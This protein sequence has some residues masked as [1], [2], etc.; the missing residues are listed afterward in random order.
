MEA[1]RLG[2]PNHTPISGLLHFLLSSFVVNGF[3]VYIYLYCNGSWNSNRS[4]MYK[5]S[6]LVLAEAADSDSRIRNSEGN[7]MNDCRGD[8]IIDALSRRLS[9]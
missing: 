1:K 5:F 6:A 2:S 7:G 9:R 4:Y 3:T 8:G